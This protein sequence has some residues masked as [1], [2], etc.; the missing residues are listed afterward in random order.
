MIASGW[1]EVTSM[2]VGPT[3]KHATIRIR[4]MSYTTPRI[5]VRLAMSGSRGSC[6]PP[7]AQANGARERARSG[8]RTAWDHGDMAL[9]RK[10]LGA[11]ENV[12][13]HL[14]THPKALIV[15]VIVLL[16][17]IAAVVLAFTL[18]PP[19][20]QPW[21]G[22]AVAVLAAILRHRVRT[23]AVPALGHLDVHAHRPPRHHAPRHPEQDRPRPAADADQ[24]RH[25]RA[26]AVRSDAGLRHAAVHDR[27]G[28]AGDAA[29]VPDVERVHVIMT[30]LLFGE[31]EPSRG[32][33]GLSL[34]VL[35]G[36]SRSPRRRE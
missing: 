5:V 33:R 36:V 7:P 2:A 8:R 27:R 30:E 6:V 21:A 23:A 24:Q 22:I 29:D 25:L 15:P 20:V 3:M 16:A 10:L 35:G 13:L 26:L 14:R 28:R 31:D 4:V 9:P 17:L 12:V 32:A 34:K 11:D 19:E 1:N 18:L